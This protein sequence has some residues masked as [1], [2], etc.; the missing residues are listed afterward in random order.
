[1]ADATS[2][3]PSTELRILRDARCCGGLTTCIEL[4]YTINAD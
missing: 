1:M 2:P 4:I 3:T